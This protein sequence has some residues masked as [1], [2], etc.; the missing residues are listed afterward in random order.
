MTEKIANEFDSFATSLAEL[1][2]KHDCVKTSL[3]NFII[4]RTG[5]VQGRN[6]RTGEDLPMAGGRTHRYFFISI[7]LFTAVFHEAA[8]TDFNETQIQEAARLASRGLDAN[9]NSSTVEIEIS[10]ALFDE[11]AKQLRTK[12]HFSIPECGV[13]KVFSG[14]PAMVYLNPAG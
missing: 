2:A 13:I 8:G 4:R 6:P 5:G 12:N 3:G 7:E 10:S 11:I 9:H 1:S 14:P